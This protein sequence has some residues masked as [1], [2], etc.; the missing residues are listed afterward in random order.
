MCK[1]ESSC[2]KGQPREAMLLSKDPV[3]L[4]LP[5]VDVPNDWTRKVLQV[6]SNLMEAAGAG[7]CLY[8][9]VPTEDLPPG[10]LRDRR[11]PGSLRSFR[12]RMIEDQMLRR[13]SSSD[14]QVE[15]LNATVGQGIR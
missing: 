11:N 12:D 8:K 10:N 9:C 3:V 5:V 6:A 15:F 14:G 7:R 13:M 4:S 2:V 1:P